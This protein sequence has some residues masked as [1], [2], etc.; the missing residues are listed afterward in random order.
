M[1]S[2]EDSSHVPHRLTALEHWTL[3]R[4]ATSFTCGSSNQARPIG[5]LRILQAGP[6]NPLS[7]WHR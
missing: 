6:V 4:C 5:H 2:H 3:V 7:H 1:T